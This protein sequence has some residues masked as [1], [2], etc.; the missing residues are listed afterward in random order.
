MTEDL[1]LQQF[2]NSIVHDFVL[3]P[4]SCEEE[5]DVCWR[6]WVLNVPRG[7]I[8]RVE[9]K[10][11]DDALAIYQDDPLP[12]RIGVATPEKTEILFGS[13][14]A[15]GQAAASIQPKCNQPSSA[16]SGHS[17]VVSMS[18]PLWRHKNLT[19]ARSELSENRIS[20][21]NQIANTFGSTAKF[22]EC[23]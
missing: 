7:Q 6:I 4:Y 8:C 14:R 5:P 21:T 17:I 16:A 19:G 18:R 23:H 9:D 22:V 12:F 2:K 15:E 10:L 13:G 1:K 11:F 3:M 20:I